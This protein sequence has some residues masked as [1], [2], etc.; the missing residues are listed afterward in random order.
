MKQIPTLE[1]VSTIT[2]VQAI[3]NEAETMRGA[4]FFQSPGNARSRRWYESNHSHPEVRWT[5]GKGTYTASYTVS[6]S[7]RN[8]YASGTYTKDG[9]KTT[10]T[11]IK[12]S[13]NRMLLELENRGVSISTG[14]CLK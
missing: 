14:E 12:N 1:L 2:A 10:L 8:V 7:C 13:L 11:A 9:K 5:D 3:V 4:Y 6:C